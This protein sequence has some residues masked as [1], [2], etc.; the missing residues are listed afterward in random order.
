MFRRGK[1]KADAAQPPTGASAPNP[2]VPDRV[3]MPAIR[4]LLF[5]D[6]DAEGALGVFGTSPRPSP[7][8]TLAAAVARRDRQAARVALSDVLIRHPESRL[9]LQAW[10]L[11]REV[12]LPLSETS[13]RARGVI[14]EMGLEAG[15]DTVAGYD[16]GSAR[17]LGQTGGGVFWEAQATPDVVIVS[18]IDALLAA[19]Q[20]VVDGGAP[21]TLVRPGP[22][23]H[24]AAAI[25]VLTEAGFHVGTDAADELSQDRL[26][27]P[28]FDAAVALMIA[29][30][31][32]SQKSGSNEQDSRAKAPG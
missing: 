21:L 12:G 29:L 2:H 32:M 10:T 6:L 19:G 27:G 15:V 17:Y 31:D 8:G 16:D 23:A 26:G 24:G 18:A 1:P 30:I 5:A 28:V 13:D 4:D 11:A 7:L 9:W 20:A 3:A 22:P 25:T 14:V